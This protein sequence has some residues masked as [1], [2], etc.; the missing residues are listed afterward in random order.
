[1]IAILIRLAI[2]AFIA[3]LL[4]RGVQTLLPG[5]RAQNLDKRTAGDAPLDTRQCPRCAA[6]VAVGRAPACAQDDCPLQTG[7]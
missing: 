2:L 3:F 6:F 7:R 5:R 1:M 4:W